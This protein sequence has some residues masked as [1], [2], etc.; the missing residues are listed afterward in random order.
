M[1]VLSGIQ[2]TGQLHI[3]NYLGAVQHW[4]KLQETHETYFAVVDLH[5]LTVHQ[6]PRQFPKQTI[7]KTAELLAA[8]LEPE[9][10]TLFLQSHVAEHTELAWIFNTLV[11][12]A[13][14][15]RMTQFKDKAAKHASNINAG[16]FTYPALMAAD[17]LLYKAEGVPIGKDQEQHL[18][19]TRTIAK[20]F[21][22][23]YGNTFPEPESLVPEQ[24]AKIMSLADPT[25]KMSKSDAPM[26][27]ISPFDMPEDIRKKIMRATTDTENRIKF[28]PIKKPGI[29][30]LLTIYALFAQ[31]PV[32]DIEK[33]FQNKGYAALKK[34][35]AEL[36]IEKLEPFARKKRELENRDVYLKE[37]LKRGAKKASAI[38]Q[39]TM[40]EVR[41]SIGLIPNT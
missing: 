24:G 38:A 18:E 3:G 23:Q 11:P 35:T 26:S 25:K 21:N 14:L 1:R 12:I 41:A 19:L 15:Q 7:Q 22:A 8:G 9:Q 37:I 10:C 16:L 34:E 20:K 17:I 30:N 5:A 4:T 39:S 6:D 2:P 29:S 33:R 27:Y 13:E 28:S 36:L 40:E 31:E 32:K